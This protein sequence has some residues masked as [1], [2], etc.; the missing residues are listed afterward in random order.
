[1]FNPFAPDSSRNS[2]CTMHRFA[3][4][5]IRAHLDLLN[6]YGQHYA[7]FLHDGINYRVIETPDGK[8]RGYYYK[9][10]VVMGEKFK[11]VLI[12]YFEKDSNGNWKVKDINS[13]GY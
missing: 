7:Y 4:D 2:Y 10:P 6:Q 11:W 12:N 1:M 9:A 13:V 5:A 8:Q 3:D